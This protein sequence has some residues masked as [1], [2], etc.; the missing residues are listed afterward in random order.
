MARSLVRRPRHP[1]PPRCCR[2]HLPVYTGKGALL[3]PAGL[4][5]T[6]SHMARTR[7]ARLYKALDQLAQAYGARTVRD[8][9]HVVAEDHGVEE[10]ET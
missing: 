4:E 9:A 6:D 7:L 8:M 2:P 10:T 3:T 1:A 5:P